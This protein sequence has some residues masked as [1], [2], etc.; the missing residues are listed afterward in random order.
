MPGTRRKNRRGNNANR[1]RANVV[2]P[3]PVMSLTPSQA[4]ERTLGRTNDSCVLRGKSQTILSITPT[5]ALI[6][7]INPNNL[8]NRATQLAQVFT[9]FRIKSMMVKITTL[10]T[11]GNTITGFSVGI[12]DDYANSTD[13]P[14]TIGQVTDLRSSTFFTNTVTEPEYLFWEPISKDY[15]YYCDA[16]TSTDPRNI[17][18]G[19]VY[20]AT[21]N[22]ATTQPVAFEFEYS[23]V[24]AGAD[25]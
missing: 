10:L 2:N 15:W 12:L 21:N 1:Q 4:F 19:A 14:S 9:R 8:G 3:Q 20:A 5:A 6:L 25:R 24:F 16:P 22:G 13:G 11:T 23:I 18:P 7:P 17:Y